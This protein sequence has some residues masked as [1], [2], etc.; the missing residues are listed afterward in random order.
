MQQFCE[1]VFRVALA[2]NNFPVHYIDA[3]S[4]ADGNRSGWHGVRPSEPTQAGHWALPVALLTDVKVS[5]VGQ[6][7]RVEF[8]F[9]GGAPSCQVAY[10]KPPIIAD[11]SGLTVS[12]A[13]SAFIQ[14]VCHD[15]SGVD[16]TTDAPV[17]TYTGLRRIP[18]TS[19]ITEV[20]L[21]G[22]FEAVLHW[23]I[24]LN[25]KAPMSASTLMTGTGASIIITVLE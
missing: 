9:K 20:V 24:G 8:V 4:D 21:T 14:L 15:A 12:V 7:N 13:G 3:N 2:N 10:V 18:G 25:H 17:Q 5:T 11:A 16:L 19:N 6:L 1:H 23:V 22:D